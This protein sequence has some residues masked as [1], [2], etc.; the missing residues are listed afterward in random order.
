M[1]MKIR[2][3][4]VSN[5]SSSSFVVFMSEKPDTPE[6]MMEILFP[7]KSATDTISCF[8]DYSKTCREIA[9]QVFSDYQS[10]KNNLPKTKKA[11]NKEILNNLKNLFSNSYYG[12]IMDSCGYGSNS[13]IGT[14]L[15]LLTDL[16]ILNAQSKEKS[17][18]FYKEYNSLLEKKSKMKNPY[19]LGQSRSQE[20]VDKYYETIEN[21]E[22]NDEEVK[23]IRKLH[24]DEQNKIYK[25]MGV[26]SEKLG[27][28]DAEKLL[29]HFDGWELFI[30]EY[31]DN[32]G[33]ALFEHGSIFEYGHARAIQF[34]HH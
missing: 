22:Q 12:S 17:D 1:K 9:E 21:I 5:S 20:Y 4:F 19:T 30:T 7:H 33:Q 3:G 11:I 28:I 23:Q 34:S 26:I 29:K 8:E 2:N 6:K 32:D 14:D 15:S 31:S 16:R 10:Y 18:I 13:F 27:Q 25:Q 24:F